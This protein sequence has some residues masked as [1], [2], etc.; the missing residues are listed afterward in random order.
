MVNDCEGGLL[1]NFL[2][3]AASIFSN[4]ARAATATVATAGRMN[5]A[6]GTFEVPN[7]M[8]FQYQVFLLLTTLPLA[9]VFSPSLMPTVKTSRP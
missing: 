6:A 4:A 7:S 5:G 3:S 1:A 9:I 2:M 8:S